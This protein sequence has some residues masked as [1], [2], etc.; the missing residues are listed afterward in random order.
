[1]MQNRY[2]YPYE[3]LEV[4][5]LSIRFAKVVY[6]TTAHFPE[7]EKF[8]LT[9]QLRRASVSISS[10]IAEGSA[11]NSSKDQARFYEIAFGSLMEVASQLALALELD[12][13]S[14]TTNDSLRPTI[15][16]LA[17]KLNA[18]RNSCFR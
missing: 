13:I 3:K 8:G 7:A 5:Q 14:T 16:E 4:W 17:N 1:M 10:N 2:Q 15:D 6:Q 11:R 9:N 12:Y 18:L